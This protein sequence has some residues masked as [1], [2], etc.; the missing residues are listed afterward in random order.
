MLI[1]QGVAHRQTL[2]TLSCVIP[3][4][5]SATAH[6]PKPF[7]SGRCPF[8]KALH[9]NIQFSLHPGSSIFGTQQQLTHP[10]VKRR[11]HP[12]LSGRIMFLRACFVNVLTLSCLGSLWF[13][14]QPYYFG[15]VSQKKVTFFC[16]GWESNIMLYHKKV[17]D[18]TTFTL[19]IIWS[20]RYFSF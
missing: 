18:Y 10:P 12:F 6:S 17:S 2:F 15:G 5:D 7:L 9:L 16:K 14:T 11:A 1:F 3:L 20:F 4:W 13:G 19:M 8:F